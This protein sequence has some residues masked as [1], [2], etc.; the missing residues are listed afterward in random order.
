MPAAG[1]DQAG[2]SYPALRTVVGKV[3]LDPPVESDLQ[4]ARIH[5]VDFDL[6]LER[7]RGRIEEIDHRAV[8]QH[9]CV[10]GQALA[11]TAAQAGAEMWVAARAQDRIGRTQRIPC[12][13]R[14]LARTAPDEFTVEL[15]LEETERRA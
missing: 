11:E 12:H 14:W 3:R 9:A 2:P 8:A 10:V 15:G 5:A 7:R 6:D 13:D 1:N 4:L